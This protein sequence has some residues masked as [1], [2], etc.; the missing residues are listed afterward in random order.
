MTKTLAVHLHL[1]YEKQLD[2]VLVKLAN[3]REVDYDLFVTV[4]DENK[5]VSDKLKSFNPNVKIISVENRGYDVGPFIEFLHH[6]DLNDYKYVLKLHTKSKYSNNYTHLNNMRFDNALWGK[7][8]WDAL[9]ASPKRVQKDIEKLKKPRVGMLASKYCINKEERNY[10]KLLSQ[11][12]QKLE[13]L[14]LTQTNTP[15]FVAGSMFYARADLL[16]PL[17]KMQLSDFAP[18]DGRVKEGTLAH[19][20]ERV[21]G[22]V[23]KEQGYEIY[24]VTDWY[25]RFLCWKTAFKRFLYQRKVTQSGKLLI[26]VLKLPI[27]SK[28]I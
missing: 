20:V 27:Y 22:E 14:E 9:L 4:T 25:P 26:K 3:L 18:T 7:V 28:K 2:E 16:K 12:N 1:F 11:I 19:V 15:E 24:G 13:D 10:K 8:L 21:M 23:I 5:D 6:I 17:L